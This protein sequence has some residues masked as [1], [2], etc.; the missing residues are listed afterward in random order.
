DLQ[1]AYENRQEALVNPPEDADLPN[2]LR[3]VFK[4]AAGKNM[5]IFLSAV[6]AINKMNEVMDNVH[7]LFISIEKLAVHKDKDTWEAL[8]MDFINAYG[9][10]DEA[11][12]IGA[13]VKTV[14]QEII[15]AEIAT[16]VFYGQTLLQE[17]VENP[18]KVSTNKE[19][20]NTLKNEIKDLCAECGYSERVADAANDEL[21]AGL[22]GH[23]TDLS[24][25]LKS[26]DTLF[27]DYRQAH[28]AWEAE[29]KKDPKSASEHVATIA[30]T[31]KTAPKQY[32]K[33]SLKK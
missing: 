6:T 18:D 17:V 2:T 11:E 3:Q 19:L 14:K 8:E 22:R 16:N 28:K 9:K 7:Q 31:A 15:Q 25:V 23:Q 24:P 12:E 32:S 21:S 10:L 5:D 29:F 30:D 1:R 26:L 13:M 27:K 33:P 20:V 4:G